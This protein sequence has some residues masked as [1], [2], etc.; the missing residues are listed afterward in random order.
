VGGIHDSVQFW[1]ETFESDVYVENILQQG[2]TI[3]VKMSPDEAKTVYLERNNKSA[4]NEA[5]YVLEEVRRLVREGQ[6]VETKTPPRCT[7]PLSVAFKVNPDG[8]IK[9]RLVIDLSRWV[10]K[11]VVPDRFW[12]VRFQDAL[13]QS[14]QG[15]FQ[16]VYDV[17]KAY[18]HISLHPDSYDL[19]GF[20]VEDEEGR[21]HY[22]HFVVVVFGLGPAGQ[23]LGRVMRPILRYLADH[24]VRNMTW[25][26]R[27][28]RWT[29][30]R[31]FWPSFLKRPSTRS[32]P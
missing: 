12:M 29:G 27:S 20:C 14:N 31:E 23:A 17:S 30:S 4:R 16:N 11:F 22:Y 19:V 9:K 18:H 13:A 10:N 6:V 8:S 32:V 26:S 3:P 5:A 2:Y 1:K 24:G 15:D 7:N 21:E 25:R 28:P